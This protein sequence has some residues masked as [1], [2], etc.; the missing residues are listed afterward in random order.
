MADLKINLA[1]WNYD[2]T[3]AM[4]DGSVKPEGVDMKYLNMF[5]ADSFQRMCRD[6][7]Y[8]VSELGLTFYIGSLD[9]PDRPFVAI[10]IFPLRFFR[11]SAIYVN[12]D[13]VKAP[14]DIKGKEVGELFIYGHDAGLWAKGIL[15]EHYG[16]PID[17][18]RYHVGGIDHFVPKWDWVPFKPPTDKVSIRQLGQ[19]ESLDAMLESGQIAALYSA[20]TPPS[21]LKG[22]K[23]VARL[24]PDYER[25]EREYFRKT[26]IFPIMHTVAMRRDVYEQ[27]RWLAQ[28]MVKAFTAARD[29]AYKLYK[30]GDGLMHGM[31]M[32]PWF[33]AHR[34]ENRKL[35]G[36]DIYPYGVEAN[37]KVLE[38]FC[39]YHHEQ[40]L[41]KKLYKP[42][43]L[44]APET[45]G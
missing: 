13:L 22:S 37:R 43:E 19:N 6:K 11:H 32:M 27:N 38:T 17:S 41:S 28:S 9:L 5:P 3:R 20:L 15:A 25:E 24:F 34:D 16:V 42:E 8:E 35:I 12:T 40:G 31:F 4:M 1:C 14:G 29:E 33:T 26:N 10:P 21:F 39:R 18:V 2:R 36:D 44:F 23:K 7:E 45:L 30:I